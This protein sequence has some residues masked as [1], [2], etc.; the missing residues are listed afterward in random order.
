MK[1]TS[2]LPLLALVAVLALVL[3]SVGTAVAG[4]ALTKSKVKKIATKV[5][6]QQGPALTVATANNANALA[7]LPGTAYLDN[8]TVYSTTI[9]TPVSHVY[10]TLPLTQGS[11]H[12]SFSA[13]LDGSTKSYCYLRQYQGGTEFLNTADA[14]GAEGVS[15]SGVVTVGAGQVVR[16]YCSGD[17]N[18]TTYNTAGVTD[19][20]QVAVTPLDSLANASLAGSAARGT[21][22]RDR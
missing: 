22:G 13:Y 19:P 3:G 20:I 5:V 6:K 2:S 15:G 12:I 11:Y 1:R 16:L 9:S 4:S 10:I 7:G 14:Y 18:F 8:V 21:G 17:A